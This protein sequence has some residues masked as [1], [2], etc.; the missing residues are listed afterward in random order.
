MRELGTCLR[1]WAAWQSGRE[2][3]SRIQALCYRAQSPP[4][5]RFSRL[6]CPP[7]G[8]RCPR[9]FPTREFVDCMGADAGAIS[10]SCAK[11]DV[12]YPT[13]M[14]S[15][16]VVLF[17]VGEQPQ[18]GCTGKGPLRA[19]T[20]G[21]K[22]HGRSYRRRQRCGCAWER[23]IPLHHQIENKLEPV[24]RVPLCLSAWGSDSGTLQVRQAGSPPLRLD[25]PPTRVR[26]SCGRSSAGFPS[27][28]FARL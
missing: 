20:D 10:N 16:A 13:N 19:S 24:C 14:G 3:I 1:T 22:H 17:R 25:R 9:C 21:D 2:K 6:Q 7:P 15:H 4:R 27:V 28:R 12:P 5:C 23:P 11:A 8:L 26:M 18:A